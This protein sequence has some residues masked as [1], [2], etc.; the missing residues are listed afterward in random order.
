MIIS[1]ATPAGILPGALITGLTITGGRITEPG[2]RFGG[3]IFAADFLLGLDDVTVRGNS[4]LRTVGNS[5]GG[6]VAVMDPATLVM[7]NSKVSGNMV[8]LR[9]ETAAAVGG[10]VWVNGDFPDGSTESTISDSEITDN[11]VSVKPGGT[12]VG[13]GLNIRDPIT[14]TRTL[15]SGNKA[16]EGGGLSLTPDLESATIDS[17]TISG[18]RGSEG[19]G[20]NIGTQ[21]PASF[22]NTTISSNKLVKAPGWGGGALYTRIADITMEH[23]TV[24]EN[25]SSR[26]RAL[27]LDSVAAG[28]IDLEMTGSAIAGPHKDCKGFDDPDSDVT[29]TANVFG[30]ASCAPA[31]I[32]TNLVANP[33]LKPL[34]DNPGA[35]PSLNFY[36]PTHMPKNGSPVVGFVTSGC[37]PPSQDQLGFDR[38]G[39]CDAGAVERPGV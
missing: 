30:D 38:I 5:F 7:Q 8:K 16:D 13:G 10:G 2:N 17:T 26:K 11:K 9:S 37:P 15:I 14:I 39:P 4:I 36:G 25:K 24:A 34:A 3:G 6:G 19:A 32:S 22:I 18:N 28:A 29:R 1:N 27:V 20:V 31:G 23:V 21:D 35:F 12:G 33:E